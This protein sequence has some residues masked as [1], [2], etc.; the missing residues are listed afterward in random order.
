M[1]MYAATRINAR[2]RGKGFLAA[3]ARPQPSTPQTSPSADQQSPLPPHANLPILNP[4]PPL[5]RLYSIC[6]LRLR[7]DLLVSL[8]VECVTI[9]KNNFFSILIVLR[10]IHSETSQQQILAG[11]FKSRLSLGAGPRFSLCLVI[12]RSCVY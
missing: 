7:N 6:C 5:H 12:L 4:R 1:D 9:R 2:W 3:F 11:I 10:G 8:L